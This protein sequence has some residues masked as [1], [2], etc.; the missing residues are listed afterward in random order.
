MRPTIHQTAHVAKN[1]LILGLWSNGKTQFDSKWGDK[2]AQSSA[3]KK[4]CDDILINSGLSATSLSKLYQTAIENDKHTKLIIDI[5]ISK[6]VKYLDS[7]LDKNHPI[8][9]G[10]D[11]DLNYKIN[12][13]SDHSTDHFI[14]IIGRGCENNRY[15]CFRY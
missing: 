15:L 4:T 9:A 8:Q 10:V 7:E 5:N 1:I 13:N 12:N 3:C 2:K 11:H 6:G 14:V